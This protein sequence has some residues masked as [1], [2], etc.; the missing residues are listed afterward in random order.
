MFQSLYYSF[1]ERFSPL[2]RSLLEGNIF[3]V[4]FC[5]Q[6]LSFIFVFVNTFYMYY[7][8]TSFYLISRSV[9]WVHLEKL[10][11]YL[12]PCQTSLMK[13][14][15]KN[16]KGLSAFNNFCKNAPLQM[17]DRIPNT[18]LKLDSR[19]NEITNLVSTV[20]YILCNWK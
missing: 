4:K 18:H 1:W 10:E 17:F 11:P 8:S 14:F 6:N 7:I 16:S 19:F 2:R 13:C 5:R 15:W 3:L 20:C 9:F 12:E